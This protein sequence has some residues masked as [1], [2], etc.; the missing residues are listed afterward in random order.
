MKQVV[1]QQVNEYF[2]TTFVIKIYF[3]SEHLMLISSLKVFNQSLTYHLHLGFYYAP[4]PN[5]WGHIC[6]TSVCHVH[7]A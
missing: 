6:L 3:I 5:R 2:L 4:A 7:R 1:K